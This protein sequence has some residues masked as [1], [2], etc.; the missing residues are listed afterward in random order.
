MDIKMPVMDGYTA[1]KIIKEDEKLKEIPLIA[2]T[3]SVMGRDLEK[4]KEHHFDGYLRKPVSQE[5][6]LTEMEKFLA[7]DKL[8]L[9]DTQ[10]D[11]IDTQTYTNLPQV[12][13]ALEAEH[14][15]TW[16]AIKDKG[17]FSLISDFSQSLENLGAQNG[18]TILSQYAKELQTNCDSFDIDKI[19][20]MMNSYPSLIEK[21]RGLKN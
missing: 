21:L 16:K 18:I 9:L 6:I 4:I 1:T 12:I 2:L 20:F 10:E 7:H 19:D 8:E 5:A 3:A 13:K 14:T 11:E 17:D 15:A